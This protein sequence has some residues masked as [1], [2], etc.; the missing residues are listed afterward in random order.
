[1]SM[2]Q[3]LP[4]HRRIGLIDIGT[5]TIRFLIGEKRNRDSYQI[6]LHEVI[7]TRLGEGLSQTGKIQDSGMKRT[8]AGLRKFQEIAQEY[9]VDLLEAYATAW[10]RKAENTDEMLS[11]LARINMPVWI[12]TGEEEALMAYESVKLMEPEFSTGWILDI[13]GGSTEV[14]EIKEGNLSFVSS[15]PIG[16]VVLTE[17][18]FKKD[19]PESEIKKTEMRVLEEFNFLG[20]SS[21]NHDF[22]SSVSFSEVN[23]QGMKSMIALGGTGACLA[24]LKVEIPP[25]H[26]DFFEK[27]Q[28]LFLSR[29][30]IEE[31]FRHLSSLSLEQRKN[32]PGMEAER[33]DILA[34]GTLILSVFLKRIN[35]PGVKICL[36]SFIHG[37]LASH[38]K[39]YDDSYMNRQLPPAF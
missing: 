39:R 31:E 11:E 10:A 2:N 5:N 9:Q 30:W 28:G 12:L 20:L 14:L 36:Y 24:G 4:K 27:V 23:V 38:F 18:F 16:A 34:A 8:L 29:D 21:S 33:A 17:E 32:L 19:S 26:P 3:H 1:M 13:G 15:I 37:I 25:S 7:T 22:P 6:L 35:A